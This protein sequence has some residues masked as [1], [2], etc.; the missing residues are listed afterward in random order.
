M[1]LRTLLNCAWLLAFVASCKPPPN[2]GMETSTSGSGSGSGSESSATTAS[3]SGSTTEAAG[4]CGVGGVQFGEVCFRRYD[5]E[6]LLVDALAA[7]DVNGDGRADLILDNRVAKELRIFSWNGPDSY[8]VSGAAARKAG[9]ASLARIFVADF[10]GDADLDVGVLS[11]PFL[12]LVS[13]AGGE[14]A[15]STERLPFP[16]HP[17][18]V[19]AAALEIDGDS[20]AE[21]FLD[22]YEGA[23][24]WRRSGDAF[25]PFGMTYSVPDCGIAAEIASADFNAD[26]LPD[27]VV[28]GSDTACEGKDLNLFPP[29]EG[30]VLLGQADLTFALSDKFWAGTLPT[31]A[32]TGDFDGDG[33]LDLAVLNRYSQDVSILLGE[34][35]GSFTPDVRHRP[36][37][38]PSSIGAGDLD[39]DGADEI[40]VNGEG[41]AQAASS[42][43]MT[44]DP[45][46]LLSDIY[47]PVIVADI[48]DDGFA[49]VAVH[50]R[51]SESHLVLLVS[52]AP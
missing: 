47:G 20:V 7:G 35:D 50:S 31:Q 9:G 15:E 14:P 25:V 38:L 51:E 11:D 24:L 10:D 34:G 2:Q 37:I 42:P 28:I 44:G 45:V 29:S 18:L 27:V 36:G 4:P 41:G 21:V 17:N 16:G 52:E 23:Q 13:L 6:D 12:E 8:Q 48:N 5:L 26:G 30:K 39:G 3:S 22:T 46:Q 43:H 49:D 1:S 40:I 33:N 19:V 32:L